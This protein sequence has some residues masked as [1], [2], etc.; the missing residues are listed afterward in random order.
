MVSLTV[1]LPPTI[2]GLTK[3]K[4]GLAPDLSATAEVTG[5]EEEP[6]IHT[7]SEDGLLLQ[8]DNVELTVTVTGTEPITYRMVSR[9]RVG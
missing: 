2:T 8:G 5:D 6:T 1:H 3:L 9:G 4:E 7:W